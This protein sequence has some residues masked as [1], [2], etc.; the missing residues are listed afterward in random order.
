[1]TLGPGTLGFALGKRYGRPAVGSARRHSTGPA[2]G[3]S[4]HVGELGKRGGD[5]KLMRGCGAEVSVADALVPDE[6]SPA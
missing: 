1:M 4:D 3:C 5:P 6:S 2:P